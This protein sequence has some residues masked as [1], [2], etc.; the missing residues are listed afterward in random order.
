M[1][2]LLTPLFLFIIYSVSAQ[3]TDDIHLVQAMYGKDKRDLMESYMQFKDSASAKAFWKLYDGYELER[4]KLGQ[5]YIAILQKYS[6]NFEKLD[7][8]KADALV[9]RMAANNQAYENLY[10]TYYKKMK[11]VVGALKASQFFQLESYL[12]SAVKIRV[13]DDIPFIGEI[14]RSKLNTK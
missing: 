7:D 1:K 13:M 12:R 9:T 10:S 8:A 3:T 2:K 14:D 4:K 5:D 11:P 6:D